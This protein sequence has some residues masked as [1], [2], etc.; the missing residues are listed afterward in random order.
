MLRAASAHIS[1]ET[2]NLIGFSRECDKKRKKKK[3]KREMEASSSKSKTRGK[4][5]M[6]TEKRKQMCKDSIRLAKKLK[7]QFLCNPGCYRVGASVRPACFPASQA[8]RLNS[9][10]KFTQDAAIGLGY[11]LLHNVIIKLSCSEIPW[12]NLTHCRVWVGQL[13]IRL[14]YITRQLSLPKS[15]TF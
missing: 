11:M 3:W 14:V 2:Q 8:T 15:W 10:K 5:K 12:C 1:F 6:G 9:H 13:K 7:L 4:N